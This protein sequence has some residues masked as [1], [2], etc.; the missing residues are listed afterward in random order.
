MVERGW[1]FMKQ[2]LKKLM[3]SSACLKGVLGFSLGINLLTFG[4]IGIRVLSPHSVKES[5]RPSSHQELLNQW[6]PFTT[7]DLETEAATHPDLQLTTP[8][9]E[10]VSQDLENPSKDILESERQEVLTDEGLADAVEE[11]FA[12]LTEEQEEQVAV[13]E[14]SS[15]FSVQ[16]ISQELKQTLEELSPIDSNII[17]YDHLRLVKVLHWGFDNQTHMGELIVHQDVAKEVAEIFEEVYAVR[18]P[19]EKMRLISEYENSD[20][21]SME[22]NNTSGFNFRLVTNGDTYSLHAYGLAIDVNPKMNPYVSEDYVL[23][24]NAM[25]Y[26]DREQTI[27][28]MIQSGDALHQAFTSRGWE[29]GG[30]WSGFKDYQHFSKPRQKTDDLQ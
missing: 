22:A 17:Q 15:G 9:Q 18:Y 7:S 20:E 12:T 26:V 10:E 19:I 27:P 28:G 5:S 13:E 29:W 1:I 6:R 30:D 3:H 23:P 24:Q 11:S 14:I 8:E 16:P 21:A 2:R 4:V 25:A